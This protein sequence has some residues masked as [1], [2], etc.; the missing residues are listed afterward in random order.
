MRGRRLIRSAVV[1]EVTAD[2]GIV[3]VFDDL[4]SHVAVALW[5]LVIYAAQKRA[6][7]HAVLLD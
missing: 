5:P 6:E 2:V 7:S 4:W 1:C 3:V